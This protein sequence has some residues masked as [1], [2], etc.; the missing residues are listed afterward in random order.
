[1]RSPMIVRRPAVAVAGAVGLPMVAAVAAVAEPPL[2]CAPTRA[3][4]TGVLVRQRR[5]PSVQWQR[6]LWWRKWLRNPL[7]RKLLL[8]NNL[9]SRR[10]PQAALAVAVQRPAE[11]AKTRLILSIS[12]IGSAESVGLAGFGLS[13]T[14]S[15]EVSSRFLAAVFWG[16]GS[17]TSLGG[18][19]VGSVVISGSRVT[20]GFGVGAGSGEGVPASV[21]VGRGSSSLDNHG[22]AVTAWGCAGL[23]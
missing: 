3:L 20:A 1:M 10:C 6:Q 15:H 19:S 18:C 22:I 7:S 2:Q 17:T 13:C 4:A 23:A 16:V 21:G 9:L 12:P 8:P 5:P 14:R 11:R